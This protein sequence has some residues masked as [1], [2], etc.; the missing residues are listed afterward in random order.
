MTRHIDRSGWW[1]AQ[2]LAA[3]AWLVVVPRSAAAQSSLVDLA[4]TKTNGVSAVTA[5]GSTTYTITASNAGPAGATG[6]IVADSF[7]AVLTCTWVCVGAGG[8]TCAASGSGNI[9]D[10]VNLPSGGS[11]TYTAVCTVSA[12][13]SGSLVNVATVTPPSGVTDPTP[14]NNS[15][16]DSDSI[17]AVVPVM[18]TSVL[19]ALAL[20]LAAAVAW[21]LSGGAVRGRA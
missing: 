10:I 6:A 16:V 3:A 14:G 4:I 5:G 13:A 2:V 20:V 17:T 1:L 19:I 11:A 7:P 18:P 9:S 8:G 12:A 21:R 15:A